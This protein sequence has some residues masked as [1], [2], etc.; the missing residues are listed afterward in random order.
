MKLPMRLVALVSCAC[1]GSAVAH[2]T[3]ER[4]CFPHAIKEDFEGY[5]AA[6]PFESGQITVDDSFGQA[7][8]A[9]ASRGDV[10]HVL[11]I[12]TWYGGGSTRLFADSFSE[13]QTAWPKGDCISNAT[14]H[15]CHA[16]IS[17]FELYTPAYEYARRSLHTSP[18]W[19]IHGSAVGVEGMLREDEIADEDKGEHFRL[20]Y[21]R[22]RELMAGEPPKLAEHCRSV[23]AVDLALLDGNEY[24][25]WAERGWDFLL[26]AN[27]SEHADGEKPR[28]P[29]TRPHRYPLQRVPPTRPALGVRRRHAPRREGPCSR[30]VRSPA[31]SVQGAVHCPARHR[32]TQDQAVLPTRASYIFFYTSEHADGVR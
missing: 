32:N 7:L 4:T 25:G 5:T 18:V 10:H 8:M 27:I 3:S 21:A 13:L 22:D 23:P 31:D 11:E 20:Y 28:A 26:L 24:T 6:V 19:F 30:R 12:G 17:S 9:L 15:C 14:H 29:A 16:F 2:R 1:A